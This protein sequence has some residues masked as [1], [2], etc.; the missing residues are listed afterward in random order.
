M[1]F[2]FLI[3]HLTLLPF[4]CLQYSNS[5]FMLN[6]FFFFFFWRYW[7]NSLPFARSLLHLIYLLLIFSFFGLPPSIRSGT[8]F[9][10]I[11]QLPH[12]F[13]GEFIDSLKIGPFLHLLTFSTETY[14]TLCIWQILTQ[15]LQADLRAFL[16][17]PSIGC[18]VL[19]SFHLE[20]SLSSSV[21]STTTALSP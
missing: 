14:K 17:G 9:R 13:M 10:T 21:C 8:W 2:T 5:S 6:D 19:P 18:L 20:V 3:L 4:S 16:P 11:M 15:S 1:L 12:Y 7:W